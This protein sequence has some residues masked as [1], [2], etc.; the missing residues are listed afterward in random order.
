MSSTTASFAPASD[1]AP[2][3]RRAGRHAGAGATGRDPAPGAHG[4]RG[5]RDPAP[6]SRR[7]AA[8]APPPVSP[9]RKEHAGGEEA[10]RRADDRAAPQG[11]GPLPDT[12]V[13]PAVSSRRWTTQDRRAAASARSWSRCAPSPRRRCCTR[14]ARSWGSPAAP[15]SRPRT[16]TPSWRRWCRSGSPSSTACCPSSET[17]AAALVA[18]ADPLDVGALDDLRAQLAAEVQPVLVPSQ[19]DPRGHQRRLRPQAGQGRDLGER[20]ERGRRGRRGRGAGRHPRRSPTRRPSSAGSTR[21]CS[22]RSRSGPATSTSSRARKRSMVRY[23]IDGVLYESRARR[24]AVHAVDHLAREDH[25]GAEHRREAAAA[26]RPHPPQDRRQGHRHARRHRADGEGRRAHHHPSARSREQCCTIWPTSASATTTWR[27]MDDL[28]HRPHGILLVTG[29]TGSGKTTTLYACLAKIN[30]PDLNILTIEDPVEYQLDG[31]SQVAVNDE[32]RADLRHRA[33]HRSCATI[34][35]V[36][37]VGEIRDRPTAE[38][39]IQA[40]LTGHLV[41]STIH[42]NDAAGA[43]T[44]LVDMGVQPFLVASS[45]M[46]LLAQRLVRRAVHGVPRALQAARRGPGQH[47]HRSGRLSRRQGASGEV[48]ERRGRRRRRGCCTGRARAAAPTCLG[49]GYKG[50]TAIYELLMIDEEIRQ[51]AI[52]N[53]DAQAPSSERRRA[54]GHAHAARRRR[55]EGAGRHDHHRRGDDDDHGGHGVASAALRLERPR[56]RRGRRSP[57]RARPTGPRRCARPAQ[58]RGL[59]DRD[60]RGGGRRRGQRRVAGSAGARRRV[61]QARRSTSRGTSSGCGPQEVAVF[62]RQLATLLKAGIPLAEALGALTEQADNKKLQMS[63]A[64]HPPEGERGRRRWPTRWA[65]TPSCSPS[66]TPTWSAR[67]RPPATWTRCCCAWPTS[68]TSSRRCARR[69]RGR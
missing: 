58:G 22:T 54:K 59:P 69:C 7:G 26:G 49:A 1:A 37:M 50:R 21:C 45:L 25:G 43:I 48:Q 2:A 51:L 31:I 9:R 41:L 12:R 62:T 23:R 55:A 15:T 17:G 11:G 52:K 32:D 57:G 16:S 30:S 42:T 10:F 53:A 61:L 14:S 67:A 8:P 24:P 60:A 28:I 6:D 27:Q 46:A 66:C 5:A 39:A 38:I 35:D 47:R 56:R 63:L 34:P 19:Q 65:R 29:P 68:W 44:R 18:T 33:A 3:G 64:G 4:A 40:S 36:I 13:T 20:R